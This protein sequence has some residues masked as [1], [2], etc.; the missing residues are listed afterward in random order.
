MDDSSYQWCTPSKLIIRLIWFGIECLVILHN[1]RTNLVELFSTVW[2]KATPMDVK[3]PSLKVTGLKEPRATYDFRVNADN[4][5]G[6]GKPSP[7][8][9]SFTAKPCGD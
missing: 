8:S 1:V 9:Q 2:K 5:A 7:V 3:T 6:V 4:K